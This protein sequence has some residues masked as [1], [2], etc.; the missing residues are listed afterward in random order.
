MT[1]F[2]ERTWA[3]VTKDDLLQVEEQAGKQSDQCI[4]LPKDLKEWRAYKELKQQ[5]DDLKEVLPLIIDLKKPS[6]LG[7]HWQKINEITNAKIQYENPDQM[8]IDDLMKAD[9]LKF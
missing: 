6:I 8:F 5:I 4:R 7:R 2:R 9:L 3:D 1:S